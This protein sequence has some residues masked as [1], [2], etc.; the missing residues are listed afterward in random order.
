MTAFDVVVGLIIIIC[1]SESE[2]CFE[3][4]LLFLVVGALYMIVH[5]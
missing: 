4:F 3:L 1:I 5:W 2:V